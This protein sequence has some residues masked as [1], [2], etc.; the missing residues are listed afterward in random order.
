M[1][2]TGERRWQERLKKFGWLGGS[3]SPGQAAGPSALEKAGP[4]DT[5]A[6]DAQ[7]SLRWNWFL[8]V[9]IH[10]KWIMTDGYAEIDQTATGLRAILRY[11][12]DMDPYSYVDITETP[13]GQMRAV[14]TSHDATCAPYELDGVRNVQV[15]VKG[16]SVYSIILTDGFTILGLATGVWAEQGNWT[17]LAPS[18][19]RP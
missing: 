4:G 7:A 8:S 18:I 13:D 6:P 1:A 10:G 15:M 9:N 17:A 12:P 11:A 2:E 3:R 5:P 19:P 16:E 14:V